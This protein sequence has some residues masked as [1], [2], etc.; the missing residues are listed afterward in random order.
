MAI[1]ILGRVQMVLCRSFLRRMVIVDRKEAVA[2]GLQRTHE[3]RKRTLFALLVVV[4]Y[5]L[6]RSISLYGVSM[7]NSAGGSGS[8][9]FLTMLLSGSHDRATVMALG[10]APYINASLLVQIVFAFKNAAS[11]AKV[12]K[13]ESDRWMLAVSVLISL[14]M[15]AFQ[16]F[17]FEYVPSAGPI[18][19][20]R[21]LAALGMFAG[22]M[23]TSFLCSMNEKHGIGTSMPIIL[24]NILTSL[25]QSLGSSHFIEYPAVL[26]LWIAAVAGTIA[27]ENSFVK[28]PLQ[29]VS[30]HNIHA[31][32]NYL[33]YKRAPMGMMPVMFA[34]SAFLVPAFVMRMLSEL[35][36]QNAGLAAAADGMS[37][38]R[39]LGACV[40]LVLIVVL[41]VG[42]S[43]LM[44]NPK[45]T[46]HQ[47]QRSGDSVVGI[48]AGRQ[49]E[50][51]LVHTV[52]VLSLLSGFL[53]A[54]C[55]AG[56]LALSFSSLVPVS[57]AMMPATMMVVV[58]IVCSL[59]REIASYR[60][61][62]AYR[63]FM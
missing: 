50:R 26:V 37:L 34:S 35:F 12:S 24:T 54:A 40:Y 19:A 42:F 8:Q 57:L 38:M 30:I 28:I 36:P 3:L 25:F 16:S 11:R 7:D 1:C 43:L 15:A 62:D 31:D 60:R 61:Y 48:Y 56:S 44:L 33:A 9:Y 52:L 45:E 46:A 5:M 49:T 6:C 10:I 18:W 2:V 27:M 17:E 4:I 55:M 29:R 39:P 41:S 13:L 59:C 14:A 20:L 21:L 51:Y 53:Q 23:L 32:Q 58:S 63:F 22:A 47:L